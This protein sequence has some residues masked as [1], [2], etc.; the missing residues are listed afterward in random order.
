[1]KMEEAMTVAFKDAGFTDDRSLLD[2]LRWLIADRDAWQ[3]LFCAVAT[4][5]DAA[6]K[7][8]ELTER[9][10]QLNDAFEWHD[11]PGPALATPDKRYERMS[12]AFRELQRLAWAV[13]NDVDA[14]LDDKKP[15][16]KFLAP[17]ASLTK[18]RECLLSHNGLRRPPA[19][20][21]SGNG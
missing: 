14:N 17:W 4:E 3:D 15:P 2:K 1:M 18:L 7:V 12:A 19:T 6:A 10:R 9:I 16:F 20:T 8:K 5:S 13:I 11:I 21:D